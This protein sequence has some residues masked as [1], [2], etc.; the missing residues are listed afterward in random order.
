MI[1]WTSDPI[2]QWFSDLV[3]HSSNYY[4]VVQWS[5]N[6]MI[7][8]PINKWSSNPM[9]HQWHKDPGIKLTPDLN[10]NPDLG[11]TGSLDHWNID[12]WSLD[13]WITRSLDYR[14]IDQWYMIIGSLTVCY[15]SP[16]TIYIKTCV[17]NQTYKQTVT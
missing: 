7:N 4:P 6:S 8:D 2:V 14:I 10:R 13:Y 17:H 9:I 12:H 15:Q 11:I 3:I 1:Q 16:C 5:G